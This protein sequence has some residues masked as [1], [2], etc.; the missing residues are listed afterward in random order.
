MKTQGAGA[1]REGSSTHPL[2]KAQVSSCRLPSPH[3][4]DP[5]HSLDR[6]PFP[7]H[8]VLDASLKNRKEKKKIGGGGGE[9]AGTRGG[10]GAG[11]AEG[12][13]LAGPLH[14]EGPAGSDTTAGNTGLS[15]PRAHL[16]D[17]AFNDG[18][19]REDPLAYCR[20]LHLA[21]RH[22]QPII[23]PAPAAGAAPLA[24]APQRSG[25]RRAG[26]RRGARSRSSC[27]PSRDAPG[28][29]A[30]ARASPSPGAVAR[31]NE[32]SR[33]GGA[34]RLLKG[35]VLSPAVLAGDRWMLGCCQAE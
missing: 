11:V 34:R 23:L 9:D 35:P 33:G 2:S 26:A 27:G 4:N 8:Q 13:R 16:A 21:Q 22:P 5:R 7:F 29:S 20:Q 25:P 18:F 12:T 6:P 28:L 10:G 24:H 19:G 14:P 3:A 17:P 1:H 31:E 15:R 30:V 32:R